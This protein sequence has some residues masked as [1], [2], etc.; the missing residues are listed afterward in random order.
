MNNN[1]DK[2]YITQKDINICFND[3]FKGNNE[4]APLTLTHIIQKQILNNTIDKYTKPC[5]IFLHNIVNTFDVLLYLNAKSFIGYLGLFM[6]NC[7][8]NEET[9]VHISSF[10]M[11]EITNC[12]IK[13]LHIDNSETIR[14]NNIEAEDLWI[15]SSCNMNCIE[16]KNCKVDR[17]WLY[18]VI[19]KNGVFVTYG[20]T[21]DR[22]RIDSSIINNNKK[23]D[24]NNHKRNIIKDVTDIYI[25]DDFETIARERF[26]MENSLIINNNYENIDGLPNR[27]KIY[28]EAIKEKEKEEPEENTIYPP[29]YVSDEKYINSNCE[30]WNY[31][32]V[33]REKNCM[34]CGHYDSKDYADKNNLNEDM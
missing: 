8:I 1:N 23:N 16:L 2:V 21:I 3:I 27:D 15:K 19:V 20:T 29:L 28:K 22:I 32:K 14:L 34:I 13:R 18:D 4:G 6:D 24:I 11:M 33:F 25:E 12:K 7:N 30:E 26:V 31:K 17:L 9:I 10:D 5:W